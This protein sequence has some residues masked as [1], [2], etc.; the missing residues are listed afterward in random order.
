MASPSA[1]PS[2]GSVQARCAAPARETAPSSALV[3]V[4]STPSCQA[5]AAI[6]RARSSPPTMG[7][8]KTSTSTAGPLAPEQCVLGRRAGRATRRRRCGPA[9]GGGGAPSTSRRR[10][11]LL[12]VLQPERRRRAVSR[13]RGP[14]PRSSCRCRRCAG[15]RRGRPHPGRPSAAAGRRSGEAAPTLTLR[16][17]KPSR[18]RARASSRQ[19]RR[20]VLGEQGVH[21]HHP[22]GAA[23]PS[24]QRPRRRGGTRRRAGP[25]PPRPGSPARLASAAMA[26]DALLRPRRDSPGGPLPRSAAPAACECRPGLAR[27]VSVP[28]PGRSVTSPRPSPKRSQNPSTPTRSPAPVER[29]G[30]RASVRGRICSSAIRRLPSQAPRPRRSP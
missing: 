10:H 4:T 8:L 15:G 11:R 26:L 13:W 25:A 22:L 6:R 17:S 28:N 24:G 5:R 9:S 30:R 7:S 20:L 14:R 27:R 12:D 18:T 23:Q 29:P 21:P 19:G 1:G 2:A 16:V 3:T